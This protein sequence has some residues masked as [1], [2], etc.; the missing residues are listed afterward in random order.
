M[1]VGS[2]VPGVPIMQVQEAAVEAVAL[3]LQAEAAQAAALV[4][5][6]AELLAQGALPLVVWVFMPTQE[7]R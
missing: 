3:R 6:V 4:A 1:A 5:V 2:A 7:S